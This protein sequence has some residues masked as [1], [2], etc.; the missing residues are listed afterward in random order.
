MKCFL[1]TCNGYTLIKEVVVNDFNELPKLCLEAEQ[2]INDGY[3]VLASHN[4]QFVAD[5]E[6]LTKNWQPDSEYMSGIDYA[7]GYMD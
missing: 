6:G 3:A 7:C 2:S 1:I 4:G 5:A